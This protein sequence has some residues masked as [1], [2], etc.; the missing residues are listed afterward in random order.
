[1]R[2]LARAG[3][4]ANGF[5]HALIGVIVLVVAFGGDAESD[6][7]GAFKAIAAV[8]VGAI[9]LWLLAVALCALALHH[10]ADGLLAREERGDSG[11]LG[12]WGRRAAAWGQAVVF[13]ALGVIAAAVALG[14]RPEAESTAEDASRGILSLPGGPFLL[15]A[16]GV[17]V[18][19]GGVAL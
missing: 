6:Q 9:A 12:K 2:R 14:A 15:G 3:Y 16:V 5:V 1:M 11:P 17:G 19:V 4:V 7:T 13:A 18:A 8:P 10:A